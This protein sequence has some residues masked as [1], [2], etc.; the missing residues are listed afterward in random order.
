MCP[1]QWVWNGAVAVI[2]VRER[3]RREGGA[4]RKRG[5]RDRVRLAGKGLG[6]L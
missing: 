2:E 3:D 5:I 1:L 6:N 4:R